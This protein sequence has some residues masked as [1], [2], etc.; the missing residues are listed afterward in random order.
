MNTRIPKQTPNTKPNQKHPNNKLLKTQQLL[1]TNKNQTRKKEYMHKN[2]LNLIQTT[3]LPYPHHL[4]SRKP[5]IRYERKHSRIDL[6]IKRNDTT[7]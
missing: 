7:K 2:T 6:Y 5:W 1:A 4:P 3:K